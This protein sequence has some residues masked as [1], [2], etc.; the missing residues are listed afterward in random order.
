MKK[1][2]FM[3]LALLLA[4][5]TAC[6]TS[7]TSSGGQND[8]ASSG[9][10]TPAGGSET[11]TVA[12]ADQLFVYGD[13]VSGNGCVLASRFTVGDKIVFR[14]NVIDPLTGEQVEDAKVAVHLNTGDVLDMELGLHPP[15]AEDAD[16]FWTVAYEVTEDTPTGTL[17]YFV[18]AE[19]DTKSGEFRPF[20]VAPSMLT[21]VAAEE[22]AGNAEQQNN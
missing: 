18:R 17:E 14:V 9:G 8:T 7:T 19:T 15:N 2:L 3:G 5:L 4:M 10:E 20:R 1:W 13:V 21:I 16:K 22:A 6:S 12:T 11:Q